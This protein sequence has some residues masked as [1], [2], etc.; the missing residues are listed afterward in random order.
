M[1]L[2]FT[3]DLSY[4]CCSSF[5]NSINHDNPVI[6]LI[7]KNFSLFTTLMS[8]CCPLPGCKCIGLCNAVTY[9]SNNR[10]LLERLIVMIKYSH[11]LL[12]NILTALNASFSIWVKKKIKAFIANFCNFMSLIYIYEFDPHHARTPTCD[13]CTSDGLRSLNDECSI[14]N[15]QWVS[16]ACNSVAAI[17]GNKSLIRGNSLTHALVVLNFDLELPQWKRLKSLFFGGNDPVKLWWPLKM[18]EHSWGN[19]FTHVCVAF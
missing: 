11:A 2:N 8:F 16:Q 6:P 12:M 9:Y 5:K 13:R 1:K 15:S 17:S 10:A 4:E 18:S 3:A 19:C 7:R 14:C